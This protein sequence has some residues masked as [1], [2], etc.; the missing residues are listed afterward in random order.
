MTAFLLIS[1]SISSLDIIIVFLTVNRQVIIIM[2]S[3]F[4]I[5][6]PVRANDDSFE[7]PTTRQLFW[8]QSGTLV[9][10][11]VIESVFF[12]IKE[13]VAQ[14]SALFFLNY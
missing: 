2:W 14:N 13:K 3:L 10:S 12:L 9:L 8:S 5:C 6:N 1:I 4:D 7:M 11:Y